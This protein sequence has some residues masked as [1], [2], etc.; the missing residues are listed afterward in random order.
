MLIPNHPDDERL[1]AL[2]SREPD[3]TADATLA[4]HVDSCVRCTELIAELGVLRAALA[5]LP[6]VT[7]SRPL[8]LLPP[9]EDSPVPAAD[10]IGGWARRF[11]APVLASGAALA[12]VGTIGT[13]APSLSGMGAGG[14]DSGPSLYQEPA[15]T[16]VAS[17]AVVGAAAPEAAASEAAAS[18]AQFLDASERAATPAN[19][20]GGDTAAVDASAAAEEPEEVA[21]FGLDDDG[22]LGDDGSAPT[23]RLAGEQSPWPLVLVSGVALMIAALLLRWMVSPR[24]G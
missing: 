22:E 2:A 7:P 24:A 10:R 14:A 15:A 8:R 1:S 11:F 19:E 3:A 23:A 12:L 16:A 20:G 13:A 5:D 21:T 18:P 17:D 9:V 4:A 6:E